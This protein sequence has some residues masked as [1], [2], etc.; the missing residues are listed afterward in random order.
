MVE[1]SGVAVSTTQL[2]VPGPSNGVLPGNK[3][4][5]FFPFLPFP[6]PFPFS[7]PTFLAILS[8]KKNEQTAR[9]LRLFFS[10]LFFMQGRDVIG[11]KAK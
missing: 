7:F 6:F 5:T 3:Q 9:F 11:T 2:L 10:F 4:L 1:W 8:P